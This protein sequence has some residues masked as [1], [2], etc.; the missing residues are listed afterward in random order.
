MDEVVKFLVRLWPKS[1]QIATKEDELALHLACCNRS[2]ALIRF[3]LDCYPQAVR[4]KDK[5][6]QLPLH[7]V[8]IRGMALGVEVI[9]HLVC[10][11]LESIRIACPYTYGLN[12]NSYVNYG[13]DQ[14]SDVEDVSGED[15]TSV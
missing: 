4:Y 3:L 5:Y 15:E 2:S 9:E 14:D 6:S 13:D 10:A 12:Y 1:C 8:C 7:T 11:W